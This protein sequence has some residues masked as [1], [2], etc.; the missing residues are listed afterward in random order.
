MVCSDVVSDDVWQNPFQAVADL[1]R[2]LAVLNECKKNDPVTVPFLTD[3]PSL[4]YTLSV[5]RNI[6]VA[7]HLRK[8][9]NHD[10]VRRFALK[11]GKLFIE[12]LRCGFGNDAS[13]IIEIPIRFRRNDFCGLGLCR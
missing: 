12:T 6:R 13:V 10:L 5:V 1:D 7:L 8:D 9:R 2:Y 11:S 3:F 4:S